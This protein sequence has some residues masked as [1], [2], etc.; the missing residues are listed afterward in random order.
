MESNLSFLKQP[1]EELTGDTEEDGSFLH[2]HLPCG[3]GQRDCFA[4]GEILHNL[5]EEPVW[6]VRQLD[7]MGST[8]FAHAPAAS[9][10]AAQ[11]G[12]LGLFGIRDHGGFQSVGH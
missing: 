7:R 10:Q 11:F 4:I 6:A 1:D 5:Q 9:E 12:Y 2:G 8:A 3:G